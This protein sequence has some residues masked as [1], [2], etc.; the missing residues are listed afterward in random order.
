MMFHW[1]TIPGAILLAIL[2]SIVYLLPLFIS[3]PIIII[4]AIWFAGKV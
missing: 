1:W 2:M 3:Y 4:F